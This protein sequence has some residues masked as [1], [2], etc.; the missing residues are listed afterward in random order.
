MTAPA[1]ASGTHDLRGHTP[2]SAEGVVLVL[3]GGGESGYGEVAWLGGP[4]LRMWPFAASIQ[5]RAGDRLAVLRLKNRFFGW[6]GSDR[7]PL[8]DA[9]WALDQVRERCPGL[10]V[11]LVGHSMGG[12]VALHLAGEPD[13]T[14]VVGLAP[15]VVG[16]DPAHGR[17]GLDVLLMH[18][19]DDRITDPRRTE[20]TAERLRAGGADVTWRPVEGEGHAMLRHPLT[21]H[22]EV[23][24]FVTGSLLRR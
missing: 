5:R 8:V 4:V 20:A 11:A 6:N 16:G 19:L 22:R 21:W 18:G 7:T 12:R 15:W 1:D 9:R 3:H 24:D 17:R 23:T 14:T 2:D 10:P 13:V